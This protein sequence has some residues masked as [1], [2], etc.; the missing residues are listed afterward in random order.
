MRIAVPSL[1]SQVLHFTPLPQPRPPPCQ[2][3]HLAP[4]AA[5]IHTLHQALHSTRRVLFCAG[6]DPT[7]PG[8]S[9]PLSSPANTGTG[10]GGL[11]Q[12]TQHCCPSQRTPKNQSVQCKQHVSKQG[13]MQQAARVQCISGAIFS[14]SSSSSMGRNAN[15]GGR[16]ICQIRKIDK[17]GCSQAAGLAQCHHQ[18]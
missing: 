15:P 6:A 7:P 5:A 11:N 8:L 12:H 9:S 3:P 14:S 4:S 17:E 13:C 16:S 10:T 2:H 18:M 1:E